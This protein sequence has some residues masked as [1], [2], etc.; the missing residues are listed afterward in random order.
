MRIP[1]A[2]EDVEQQELSFIVDGNTKWR[3]LW[4]LLTKVNIFLPSDRAIVLLGIY[5]NELKTYVHPKL[6]TQIFIAAL[7]IIAQ[8]WKQLRYSSVRE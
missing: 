5:P 1:N 7:F 3:T 4:K 2:D 6:C 8:I